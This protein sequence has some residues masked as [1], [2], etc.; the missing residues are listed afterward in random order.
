[1]IIGLCKEVEKRMTHVGARGSKV[2]LKVKQRKQG[3]PP[4]PKF[5]GHGSCHHLSKSRDT[6][7]EATRDWARLGDVASELFAEMK[8]E[9]EDVRGMGIVV[10]KLVLDGH[11]SASPNRCVDNWLA[12][13]PKPIKNRPSDNSTTTTSPVP[14]LWNDKDDEDC[15]VDLSREGEIALPFN[16]DDL[17]LPD[18]SQIRMS[19]VDILPPELRLQILSKMEAERSRGA[20]VQLDDACNKSL[21]R[22]SRF[23]QT[24]VKRMLQLANVKS[25]NLKVR[26]EFGHHVSVTQ[27]DCL[28]LEVQL[29]L[30]N[31]DLA[32]LGALSPERKHGKTAFVSRPVTSDSAERR[33][34]VYRQSPIQTTTSCA[35]ELCGMN[36]S[37]GCTFRAADACHFFR[38][39]VRPLALFMDE[40]PK[41]RQDSSRQ[42]AEFL[43]VCV[44]EHRLDDAACLLRTIVNRSDEWGTSRVFDG[45]FKAVDEMVQTAYGFQLGKDWLSSL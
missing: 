33:S 35:V 19:Q 36:D 6:K 23:R 45:I 25:G 24:N 30:A 4:P 21:T 3:A 26:S 43:C 28:P 16:E 34:P 1:M 42:V 39:N 8:V 20:Q 14:V 12:G 44:Q 15:V 13:R 40:N 32:S 17:A 9:K 31:A 37:S 27:L 2:T 22:D 5:L 38:N 10:S 11:E 18:L 7:N 29:Q 41:A